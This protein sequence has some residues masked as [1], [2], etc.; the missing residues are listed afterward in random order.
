MTNHPTKYESYWT[1]DFIGAAFTMYIAT[2]GNAWKILK[3]LNSYNSYKNC[4]I[5]MSQIILKVTVGQPMIISAQIFS[6]R[7]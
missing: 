4:P 5:K 2:I 7:F 3:S 1:S 6:G